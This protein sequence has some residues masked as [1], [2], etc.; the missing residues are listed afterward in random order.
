MP[1][2]PTR[3]QCAYCQR[4]QEHGGE[5]RRNKFDDTGCLIFQFDTRGCI[6]HDDGNIR[7]PLYREIPLI[8]MWDDGWEI[9][10]VD[11]EIRIE[12]IK[13]LSWDA[14][15]GQLIVKCRYQYFVNEYHEKYK[16]KTDKP[17]IKRIK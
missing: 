12:Y 9:N 17:N 10:G 4:N 11:T 3:L 15:K 7:F 1:E 2:V 13:G 5:C 16:Q 8:G 14:K 6:R